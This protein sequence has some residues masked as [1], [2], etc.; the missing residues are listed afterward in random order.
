[1]DFKEGGTYSNRRGK[2]IVLKLLGPQMRV[3]YENGDVEMLT[4]SDQERIVGNMRHPV[5]EAQQNR[6]SDEARGAGVRLSGRDL[7]R[8][9]GVGAQH[10]LYHQDGKWYENL[11]RFPGALFDPNGYVV[12]N[13]ENDYRTSPYLHIGVKTNVPLGIASIPGYVRVP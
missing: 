6:D 12:F 10:A 13:T 7:N 9:W 5:K 8:L 1:M 2:Y 4:V 11:E 3:R